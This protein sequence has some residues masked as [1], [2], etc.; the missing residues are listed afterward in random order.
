MTT[1]TLSSKSRFRS[2]LKG[3][4]RRNR[5]SAIYLFVAIFFF[6]PLQ[7]ILEIQ[8]QLEDLS[9]Y[10]SASNWLYG[11]SQV[12]T[13]ISLIA[14]VF[15]LTTAPLV[16]TLAQVSYL[17]NRRS[18]DLY[19]SLPLTR[20]PA[21]GSQYAGGFSYHRHSL[22]PQLPAGGDSRNR[23]RGFGRRRICPLSRPDPSGYPGLAD[24]GAGDHCPGHAGGYPGGQCL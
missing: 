10:G 12:Y 1:T 6:F 7:Y 9:R 2:L 3:M 15:I 16:L 5:A 20:N 4:L 24:S 22:S 14:M 11:P 8:R 19:H 17:H 13:S 23:A 18:V 21:A